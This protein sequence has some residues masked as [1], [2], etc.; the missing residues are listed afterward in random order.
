[1]EN[2]IILS[3]CHSSNKTRELSEALLIKEQK[4]T[5]NVQVKSAP[6]KLFN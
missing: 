6:L 4:P 2:V 1:M 5:L 3:K